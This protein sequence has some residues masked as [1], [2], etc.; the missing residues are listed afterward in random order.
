MVAVVCHRE[1]GVEGEEG[2]DLDGGGV[3]E[4]VQEEGEGDLGI[5]VVG[6]QEEEG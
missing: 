5:G 4:A 6:V 2:V 3:E 1:E